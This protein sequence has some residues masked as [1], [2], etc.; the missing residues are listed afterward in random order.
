MRDYSKVSPHFWIGRTGKE[1]RKAGAEAT[2]VAMYLMTSPHANMLG[3]YYLPEMYIAHETGLGIE[4]AC[5]GLQR[6]IEAGFCKYDKDSEV[7]FV[8]EM[9]RYQ[10]ADTLKDTDKRC[11]GVQNEYDSLPENPF[12]A[13]FYDKYALSFNMTNRRAERSPLQA[14]SKPLASQEQEQA[15]EQEITNPDGLV[16]AS[17]ADDQIADQIADAKTSTVPN[18][19]QQA[20]LDLYAECL[21]ELPQ[22]RAWEGQAADALRTRWR[23]VL[24]AT[25]RGSGERYATTAAE[26]VEWFRRFFGYVAGSDFLMGRKADWQAD[27]RWLVKAANFDKVLS[28]AYENGRAAA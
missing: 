2:V 12:L 11:I 5:K 28:G 15:Q 26:G 8:E 22:P 21:P 7:V 9:A 17:N 24:T 1:I 13:T 27:L 10:I 19:P 4:G 6:C 25:K 14:P 23:W 18:C 3:L 16:V 20:L